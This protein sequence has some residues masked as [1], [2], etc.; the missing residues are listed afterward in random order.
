MKT[1]YNGQM[2]TFSN[3]VRVT[4]S[5]PCDHVVTI[6][7]RPGDVVGVGHR[8][9]QYPE[10]LWCASEDGHQGWVAESYLEITSEKE[11]VA[12]REY[13]AAQLTVIE[14]E[15]LDV[16]DQQGAFVLCRNAVGAQGWVPA[17]ILEDAGT[18][19]S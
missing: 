5:R 13:D 6:H 7:M 2:N 9:Q 17:S 12:Q 19:E 3:K 11:A 14:G 4:T 10:F 8:N 15:L 18:D 1:D 16:L